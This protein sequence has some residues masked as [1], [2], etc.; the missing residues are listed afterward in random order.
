[1]ARASFHIA[2]LHCQSCAS[3][4]EAALQAVAAVRRAEV[5]FAS[6]EALIDYD[7]AQLQSENLRE[8]VAA[9]GF[10]ATLL[11]ERLPPPPPPPGPLLATLLLALPFLPAMGAMLFGRHQWM[12]P[13][14]WQWL[15][16]S[17]AQLLAGPFY[18]R[19]G[20]ALRAGSANMDV[21]IVLGTTAIYGYSSWAYWSG[22]PD[23]YF[24]ASVM[25]LALVGLGK[26]LEERAKR[27]SLNALAL[28][29]QLTPRTVQRQTAT[30]TETAATAAV[31]V[32]DVLRAQTGDRIVADGRVQA[33]S[34]WCDESH[35]TGEALPQCREPGARVLAGALVS[36]GAFSY[37]VEATGAA[38]LL[39]DLTTALREAQNSKA[40]LARLADRV[41]A[42]FV[43]AVLG[44][45][46]LTLLATAAL[47]DGRTALIHAVSVL[48]VACP[49]ALG[50]ATPASLMVGLGRAVGRGIWFRDAEALETFA[51]TDVLLL[52]KTGTLTV[53]QPHILA[54]WTAPAFASAP[55]ERWAAALQSSVR[56]PL[57]RAFALDSGPRPP[58][59]NLRVVAGA[60]VEAELDGKRLRLGSP[61]F[62]GVN[63]PPALPANPWATA[64]LVGLSVDGE[65]A[66][67]FALGDPL[68]PDSAAALAALRGLGV[69]LEMVSGD[70]PAAVAAVAASLGLASA[71]GGLSPRAKA[72]RVA[73][74]QAQ[75]RR[76]AMV[77]DGINDVPA[78]ARAD[79]GIA[80]QGSSD[81][82]SASAAL[83][84]VQPSL[85]NLA[86]ALLIARQT[87]ANIRQNLFFAF[88]YNA[89]ALPLAMGGQLTPVIAALAM[90][91]S[92]LSVLANALRLRRRPLPF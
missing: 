53:G 9:S 70:R 57:A 44:L 33:G 84:L 23:L 76:V 87:V 36:D 51:A 11:D 39:G 22:R 27:G 46:L 80:V 30:G 6:E 83:R 69:E 77:G 41:A 14:F 17:A 2:G 19:A 40:P 61:A 29:L 66:A 24:E 12:L 48:V 47:G 63:L 68:R 78:L 58:L 86:R 37:R 65:P 64:T 8:L 3:G 92:S 31:A 59:A 26:W 18:R 1:M 38:T 10:R 5:S 73:A 16:A 32:G 13:P 81:V 55:L 72:E 45:A 88:A 56:H 67:L 35:L 20:R 43:P 79:S 89:I 4:L 50:L 74:L 28:L 90:T 15:L 21:L 85:M 75:G 52:D 91:L 62:S 54:R 49:C 82:A 7:E 34:G 60:G 71:T 25:V 42:H